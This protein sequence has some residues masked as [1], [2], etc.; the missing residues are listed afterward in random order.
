MQRGEI[1]PVGRL[2]NW[3]TVNNEKGT[4]QN[5]ISKQEFHP[6]TILFS[7]CGKALIIKY[8]KCLIISKNG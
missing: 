7:G 5:G 4:F 1:L 8:C 2:K 6:E 3:A